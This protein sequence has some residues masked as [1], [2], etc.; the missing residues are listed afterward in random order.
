MALSGC[1]RRGAFAPVLVAALACGGMGVPREPAPALTDVVGRWSVLDGPDGAEHTWSSRC[2]AD[3]PQIVV[4][5]DS[6][7]IV[8]GQTEDT[9]GV[10]RSAPRGDALEIT[11]LSPQIVAELLV[12][13][14]DGRT[15]RWEGGP[16]VGKPWRTPIDD[17]EFPSRKECC[18][19]SGLVP[20]RYADV[21]TAEN[22]P[23]PP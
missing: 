17:A 6:V 22:C 11:M 19:T 5:V 4:A 16:L 1:A 8:W 15:W 18:A 20:E 23:P 13:R 3:P 21:A 14:R 12:V 2:Y 7:T 10:M 9:W